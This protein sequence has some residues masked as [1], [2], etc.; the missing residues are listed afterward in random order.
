MSLV[1]LRYF[2]GESV[3][4]DGY[5]SGNDSPPSFWQPCAT[6]PDGT[7]STPGQVWRCDG[8]CQMILSVVSTEDIWSETSGVHSSTWRL[9]RAGEHD[10]SAPRSL[11]STINIRQK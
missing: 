8:L 2:D 1:S 11:P 3:I 4:L 10:L 7:V 6:T 9:A 5:L